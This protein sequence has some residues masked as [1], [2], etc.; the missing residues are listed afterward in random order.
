MPDRTQSH[1]HLLT[2]S[3]AH[4]HT[5]THKQIH[6]LPFRP[7]QLLPH[8]HAHDHC[9]LLQISVP[10]TTTERG[11]E[12][13]RKEGVCLYVVLQSVCGLMLKCLCIC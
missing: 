10:G 13:G 5:H 4:T 9:Y 1:T 2:H 7:V 11:R 8:L 6:L 12:E 3:L